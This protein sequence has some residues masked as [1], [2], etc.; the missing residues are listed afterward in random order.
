MT[1]ILAAAAMCATG[2]F[3]PSYGQGR[4]QQKTP[5]PVEPREVKRYQ[6]VGGV[7]REVGA[8]I[9]ADSLRRDTTAFIITTREMQRQA[10]SLRTTG[11]GLRRQADSLIY[12]NPNFALRSDSMR[13]QSARL[14]QRADSIYGERRKLLAMMPDVIFPEDSL[15]M[16]NE[17]DS[18]AGLSR[19]ELRRHERELA[20]AA[21]T[22]VRYSPVFRDTMPISRMTALSFVVPGLGQLHNK[23]YWKIPMLYAAVGTTAYLGIQ[24]NNCFQ[25]AKTVYDDLIFYGYTRENSDLERVQRVMIRHNQRRQMWWGLAAATY[26]YF[27]CDGVINHP[28]G[29]N[30]VKI[31]TTLST[32]LPGAGQIYNRSY[33]KAPIVMGAFATTLMMIDWNNRG[34]QRFK[35]AYNL[36]MAGKTESIEPGLRNLD[37][38]QLLNY[39]KSYRRNRD[40]CIILTGAAY[41]LNLID[42]HVDA[43]MK[44]YD[45]SEDIGLKVEPVISQVN[46]TQGQSGNMLGVGMS[47]SF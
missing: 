21:D 32:I 38:A 11:A 46:L 9:I 37:A 7:L 47:L 25:K 17:A 41:L 19:R 45:V 44:N 22:T 40:L 33:W 12:V 30:D 14:T 39:R 43:H 5:P 34:Y 28:G 2:V 31:A 42:A 24:Q 15:A 35:L 36:N 29:S 4:R 18:L 3:S 23:Q 13:R 8:T 20:R 16:K 10:D 26:I 1:L 6:V 27:V